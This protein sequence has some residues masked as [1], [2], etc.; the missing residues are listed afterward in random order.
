MERS[1]KQA[2]Q[3]TGLMAFLIEVGPDRKYCMNP[4]LIAPKVTFSWIV[5]NWPTFLSLSGLG[6]TLDKIKKVFTACRVDPFMRTKQKI[7]GH[8]R[9]ALVLAVNWFH[10]LPFNSGRMMGQ[11]F[12]VSSPPPLTIL[13]PTLLSLLMRRS[14]RK[15]SSWI[16]HRLCM[17]LLR[18]LWASQY[19]FLRWNWYHYST[20]TSSILRC[21]FALMS[22]HPF[23]MQRAQE[24]IDLVTEGERLPMFDDWERLPYINA[25]ILE[26]LRY[27]NVTPLG[28][29]YLYKYCAHQCGIRYRYAP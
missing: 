2:E 28:E 12:R 23:V 19:F 22:L 6:K 3:L 10:A 8:L 14:R 29:Y 7:V 21:F 11:Q 9:C 18:I 20:K 24:D 16:A 5:K 26:V 4:I 17:V 1:F 13:L 25:I 27:N 15:R